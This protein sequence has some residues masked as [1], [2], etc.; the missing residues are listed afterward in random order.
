MSCLIKIYEK[1][2][3]LARNVFS[4]IRQEKEKQFIIFSEN[5]TIFFTLLQQD[6]FQDSIV[7]RVTYYAILIFHH[8]IA[9]LTE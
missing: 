6:F 1:A 7:S 5:F 3:N 2:K 9:W 4:F 8:F